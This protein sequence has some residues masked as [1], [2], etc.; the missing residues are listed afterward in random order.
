MALIHFDLRQ[1]VLCNH[2]LSISVIP[3]LSY[4]QMKREFQT[5]PVNVKSLKMIDHY[6]S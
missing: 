2:Q 1:E 6:R 3:P 5:R 4:R